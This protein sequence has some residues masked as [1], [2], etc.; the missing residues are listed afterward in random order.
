MRQNNPEAP[1]R[2][3]HLE[4]E[5][6]DAELVR[7][8]LEAGGLNCV[9]TRVQ[10]REDFVSALQQETPHV[11]FSDYTIPGFDGLSALTIAQEHDP[12]I[13]FIFVSGTIGDEAGVI[14]IKAGATDYVLK[15]RLS[16]LV[17]S[18]ARALREAEAKAERRR[19]EEHLR[20]SEER[21]RLVARMTTDAVW[22]WNLVTGAVWRNEG[23]RLLVGEKPGADGQAL[24]AWTERIHPEDRERI[25]KAREAVMSAGR[26][27]WTGEYRLSRADGSSAWVMERGYLLRDEH[28]R[29]ARMI[30]SMIDVTGLKRSEGQIVQQA[31][32]IDLTQV[33]LLVLDGQGRVTAWNRGAERV[34]G[35]T[36]QE[37]NG[38]LAMDLIMQPHEGRMD[39]AFE[40]LHRRGEWRGELNQRTKDNRDIIVDSSW[41]LVPDASGKGQSI[42]VAGADV[43][44]K[45]QLEK[46]LL[47]IQRLE[48]LGA[49]ASGMAHDLNNV[50]TP[51]L[52]AIQLLKDDA[53]GESIH[54]LIE[55]VEAS[56]RR[57]GDLVNQVLL[58]ARGLDG[59]QGTVQL[60]GLIAELRQ[61]VSETFPRSI[62][63]NIRIPDDLWT[64]IGDYTQLYQVLLNL[65]V[66][67]RDAMPGGGTLSLEADNVHVDHR[68]AALHANAAPGSY[69]RV[70]VTDT[71]TGIPPELLD[72]IFK[73]FFTT[74]EPGKGTGL[75]LSTVADIVTNHG[76]FVDVQSEVGIGS[77]MRVFLRADEAAFESE[78]ERPAPLL[79][80]RGQG[81]CVLVAEDEAAILEMT[82]VALEA[83]G[84]RVLAAKDGTDAVAMFARHMGDIHVVVADM[85]M[86]FMDG[87][88]VVRALRRLH[89]DVKLI[90][91]SGLAATGKF[92]ELAASTRMTMIQ[93][94]YTTERLLAAIHA[95]LNDAAS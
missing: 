13:P 45:K 17:P 89:P 28:G 48:N 41:R 82:K 94:P 22:D 68:D 55:M 39:G 88:A 42:L 33:A 31:A 54:K 84:Y 53:H 74:K 78:S 47:Q 25:E 11:I 10:C 14:T 70:S 36:S 83:H 52:V 91:V 93:K 75:G 23:F 8:S 4:D 59:A 51:I 87:P 58:F 1:I 60:G 67:A 40:E 61:M 2:I 16:R 43:T 3:L 19:A 66:N 44:E 90:G 46:K 7:C 76:G 38:A 57:G 95:T 27:N 85:V 49:L 69:V 72:V 50:L 80:V 77:C 79:P 37:A 86:P 5:P 24:D 63:L 62:D 56:A 18:V 34:Y 64:I 35:W 15:G 21:F 92:A 81:Q 73:P 6:K 30:A 65:C 71:G 9:M 26:T 32:L 20:I 29:P 12:D